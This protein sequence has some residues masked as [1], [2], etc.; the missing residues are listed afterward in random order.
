MPNNSKLDEPSAL[1]EQVQSSLW[2]AASVGDLE[3]VRTAVAAG[4]DVNAVGEDT[5]VFGTYTALYLACLVGS[6][7]VVVDRRP[8]VSADVCAVVK[9][10]LDSGADVETPGAGLVTG[11]SALHCAVEV[12]GHVH[13]AIEVVQ[14]L[15]QRGA[16]HS[17]VDGNGRT[18]LDTATVQLTRMRSLVQSEAELEYGKVVQLLQ[19]ASARAAALSRADVEVRYPLALKPCKILTVYVLY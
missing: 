3:G 16:N 7:G 10:L 2:E 1:H 13:Q 12:A 15:L 5:I 4:A 14:L 18:A 11:R 9:L 8:S 19:D 6:S 17:R